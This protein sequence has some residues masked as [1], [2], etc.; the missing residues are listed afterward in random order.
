MRHERW[1]GL[2]LVGIF[3]LAL[4]LRLA[5][6]W[7]MRGSPLFAVLLGDAASYDAWAQ[8]IAA[9]DWL[10][11]EVFYQAPLY[12]YLLGVLYALAGRDLFLVRLI[13]AVLGSTMC[14]L[15]ALAGRRLLGSGAG[16]AAG[17]LLALYAPAIFFDGLIQK[18]S[19]DVV[20]TALVVWTASHLAVPTAASS[21][22]WAGAPRPNPPRP[23]RP[24][25]ASAARS[26]AHD[27]ADL[28]TPRAAWWGVAVGAAT[29]ALSLTREHALIFVPTLALWLLARRGGPLG[30][31]VR[32]IASVLAG[33]LVVLGPVGIRNAVVGGEFVLTTAQFGPNFYIGNNPRADGTY[34]SLRFGRGAPEYEREDATALAE[35]AMGRRLTPGEVSAYWAGRAIDFIRTQPGAWLRLLGRKAA[36]VVNATEVLDTE[37]QASHAEQSRVLA[38][39]GA[40]AHFG[41]LLP[42]A[43]FGYLSLGAARRRVELLVWLAGAYAASVVLFYV[44]ARYRFPLVPLLGLLAG[45]GV[46][47][48]AVLVRA[49]S[50]RG[51]G[52]PLAA[53]LAAGVASHWPLVS[54]DLNRAVTEHNLG[55]AFHELGRFAEAERHY[56]RA[57]AIVPRYAPAYTNLGALYRAQGREAAA[58]AAYRRALAIDPTHRAAHFNLGNA[59]L[60]VGRPAEAV[61][62]FEHAVRLDPTS[63]EA[64]TNLGI[65]LAS[66]GRLAEAADRFR[67]AIRVDPRSAQAHYNLG[68]VLETLGELDGAVAQFREAVRV[69]PE[70]FPARYDLGRV[71]LARGELAEAL[72]HL[73]QA[74]ALDPRSAAARNNLG[75]ALAATGDL[76][77]AVAEFDA[78]VALD[79][80]FAEARSNRARARRAL[81]ASAAAAARRR[82]VARVP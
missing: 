51:V 66:I 80:H 20:L 33:V 13:Q 25:A 10:G 2:A 82:P 58:I 1:F 71:L 8:R 62:H 78:A 17:A 42:L 32:V 60:A 45:A 16:V 47:R 11:Q 9:G 7:Q 29:G 54:D 6:L 44:F 48:A 65:A 76:A 73:R 36:L 74:V 21:V 68:H 49:R 19:L 15:V 31:R 39:L 3:A 61:G 56:R 72:A 52:W 5:H 75:V 67:E 28:T 12:P 59:L 38:R 79:P 27:A 18:S 14:V 22:P 34:L 23:S 26:A 35:R 30:W 53:A 63:A 37:S 57:L 77:A 50:L 4:G 70:F 43:V 46:G 55:T 40:V 41:T 24:R 81:A 69:G 64:L